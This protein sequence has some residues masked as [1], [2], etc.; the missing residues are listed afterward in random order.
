[1]GEMSCVGVVT[2]MRALTIHRCMCRM[3]REVSTSIERV[4]MG[5]VVVAERVRSCMHP[6]GRHAHG[7][8]GQP[9]IC[10]FAYCRP[11]ARRFRCVP[12]NRRT[13]YPAK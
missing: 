4:C 11:S 10:A 8:G 12:R 6:A 9:T 2:C 7:L 3:L 5:I 1:M 13:V